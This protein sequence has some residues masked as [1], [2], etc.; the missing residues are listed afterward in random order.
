MKKLLLSL[1]FVPLLL[2]GAASE[3]AIIEVPEVHSMMVVRAPSGGGGGGG[4]WGSCNEFDFTS[5]WTG[6]STGDPN[7]AWEVTDS[8]TI[9]SNT[10]FDSRDVTY[11]YYKD[12]GAGYYSGNFMFDVDVYLNESE[13]WQWFGFWAVGNSANYDMKGY[14]DNT[15]D[16]IFAYIRDNSVNPV[17]DLYEVNAGSYVS[18]DSTPAVSVTS[19]IYL[20]IE[21]DESVGTYGTVYCRIYDD[22]GRTEEDLVNTVTL[23]LSEQQDFRYLYTMMG[24]DTNSGMSWDINGVIDSLC[25][26]EES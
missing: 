20:Q 3:S 1:L 7:S 4:G 17:V 18:G 2:F 14:V 9:T 8:D 25:E 21:R 24:Y 11:F 19:W 5:G 22:P 16:G 13:D 23:T 12:M 15:G 10:N 26:Y 6:E